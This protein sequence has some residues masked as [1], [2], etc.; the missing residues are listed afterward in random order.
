M[1]QKRFKTYHAQQSPKQDHRWNEDQLG[2]M[3]FPLLFGVYPS[4]LMTICGL[5]NF[6]TGYNHTVL[7]NRL[8]NTTHRPRKVEMIVEIGLIFITMIL[9]SITYSNHKCWL[10]NWTKS[11]FLRLEHRNFVLP[12]YPD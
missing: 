8:E 12:S 1:L 3:R 9:D 5:A 10:Q 11:V 6:Q 7:R 4:S 2:Q